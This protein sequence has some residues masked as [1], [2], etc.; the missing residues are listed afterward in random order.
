VRAIDTNLLVRLVAR[1]DPRQV[2]AAESFVAGGAWVP[3]VALVET[4]WVLDTVYRRSRAQIAD[5][6][7]LLLDHRDLVLQDADVIAAALHQFRRHP[8]V[9][10]SDCLIL[11]QARKAGHVPLGTFDRAF[12]RLEGTVRI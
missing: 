9:G 3:V 8:R 10:F 12:S 1:D 11:E 4:V 6:I 7:A 5:G 2:A